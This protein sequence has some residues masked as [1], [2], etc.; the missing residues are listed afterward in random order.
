MSK[1]M[2][3]KQFIDWCEE[4]GVIMGNCEYPTEFENGLIGVKCI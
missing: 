2:I 3:T 4:E 1:D